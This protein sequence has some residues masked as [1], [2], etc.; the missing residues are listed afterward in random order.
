[1]TLEEVLEMAWHQINGSD[2]SLLYLYGPLEKVLANKIQK[3]FSK[4][5]ALKEV[6]NMDLDEFT[7]H[8]KAKYD[9]DFDM[10][11]KSGSEIIEYL[12][13]KELIE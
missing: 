2:S 10:E 3:K 12:R 6:W 7:Q 9:I 4:R 11:V 8:I 5:E 1:M 13:N